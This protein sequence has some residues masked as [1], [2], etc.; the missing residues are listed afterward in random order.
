MKFTVERIEK[1]TLIL[2]LGDGKL[3]EVPRALIPD[4]QEGA[5]YEIKKSALE[6]QIRTQHEVENNHSY[7]CYYM[8]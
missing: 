3:I 2:E 5:V 7:E 8:F 4:A 6:M 1:D